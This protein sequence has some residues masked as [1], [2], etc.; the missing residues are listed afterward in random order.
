MLEGFDPNQIQDLEG[1]QQ[2]I[3]MLLNLVEMLKTE[4]QELREQVQRLREGV[5][6]QIR[7]I[8]SDRMMVHVRWGTA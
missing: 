7:D 4:N 8:D 3:V 1:A 2:A 6:L 5:H